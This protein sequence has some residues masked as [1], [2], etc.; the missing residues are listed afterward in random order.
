MI[1][2]LRKIRAKVG[3][4]GELSEK[5]AKKAVESNYF[6]W[7]YGDGSSNRRAKSSNFMQ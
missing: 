3:F 2:R 5:C 4:F 1:A 7:Y 6:V